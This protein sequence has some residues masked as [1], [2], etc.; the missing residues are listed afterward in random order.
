MDQENFDITQ[1]SDAVIA[2]PSGQAVTLL[3]I[4]WNSIGPEGPAPRFRF[5]AP[6]IAKL[7]GSVSYEVTEADLVALC[8]SYVIGKLAEKGVAAPFVLV[9][10][11]DRA[12]EFG[13]S[14]PEATQ[15]F[16]VFSINGSTCSREIF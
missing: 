8:Q 4:I 2:V 1:G 16:E 14:D 12:V 5:V 10:F 7:S 13:V 15:Y 11:A 9:S 6:A 3:D